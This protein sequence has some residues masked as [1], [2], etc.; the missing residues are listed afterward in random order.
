MLTASNL[1]NWPHERVMPGS[2]LVEMSPELIHF[3]LRKQHVR[4]N[5][6]GALYIEVH[7]RTLKSRRLNELPLKLVGSIPYNGCGGA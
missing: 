3:S 6:G 4:S 7:T 2:W 1:I 5:K